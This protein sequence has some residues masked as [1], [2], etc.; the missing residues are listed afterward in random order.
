MIALVAPLLW[1]LVQVVSLVLALA[2]FV[3]V[4]WQAREKRYAPRLSTRYPFR[5]ILAWTAPWMYPYQN[6]ED[7]IDGLRR[8]ALEQA[9]WYNETRELSVIDRI[10]RWSAWRNSVNNLRFMPWFSCQIDS[11]KVRSIGTA[12]ND[13]VPGW[14]LVWQGAYAGFY[15]QGATWLVHIGWE[16]R[17]D[18]ATGPLGSTDT[19]A[20]WAGPILK[21]SHQ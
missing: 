13:Q 2:G 9:W 4:D 19:R 21:I 17:P 3:L 20:G 10:W 16:L 14:F 15:R 5:E 18:D 12:R 1:L 8:G 7:G 11:P 6:E